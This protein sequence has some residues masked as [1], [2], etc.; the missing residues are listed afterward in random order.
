MN[1]LKKATRLLF[2]AGAVAVLTVGC[3]S[4]KKG[5][6]AEPAPEAE[7][8]PEPAAEPAME[9]EAMSD[10]YVVVA[11]DCLW[12]IS[13]KPQIYG[14]PYQWPLIYKSNTDQIEDADLI[15]PGQELEVP[16][17]MSPAAIEFARQHARTR[18]P[19]SLG[20]VEESDRAYLQNAPSMM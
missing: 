17:G 5:M 4:A 19:W 6:P 10:T 9:K 3:A 20:V 1:G 15:Y 18:G 12:C 11:G 14:D 8:A 7:A 16:R 2:L 13:E